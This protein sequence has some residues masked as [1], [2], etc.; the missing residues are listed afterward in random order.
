[1]IPAGGTA[2]AFKNIFE[3]EYSKLCR[4]ALTFLNDSH[5]AE[6]IVQE[7]FIK[8]WER[9]QEIIASPDMRFYLITAVRNNCITA[10]RKLKTQNV[11][12]TENT[13][14]P[15]PELHFTTR[16]YQEEANEQARKIAGALELLPPKCKEVFLLV[17]MQGLSYKQTAETLDISV[18]TVENQ[19]GKA[20][21]V[22]RENV[23]VQLLILSGL[24]SL[25][26]LRKPF[27]FLWQL[28]CFK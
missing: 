23:P 13:P 28:I 20:I 2:V 7:T 17:K 27:D 12:F 4:Y 26:D 24:L 15:E 8:I 16:Q 21:K 11:T 25:Q 14:E 1:M 18:K 3:Q 19:M 10:L 9:K 5:Q 6:D 22:L